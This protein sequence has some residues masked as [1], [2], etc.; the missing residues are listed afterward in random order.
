MMAAFVW[1][2]SAIALFKRYKALIAIVPLVLALAW[3]TYQVSRWKGR[4]A[5]A[6]ATIAKLEAA[7]AKARA[8]QIAMNNANQELNRRIADNAA[9]RHAQI[10]DAANRAV[11]DYA[12]R[13]R[14]QDYCSRSGSGV[15]AVPA[16]PGAPGGTDANADLVAVTR[17]DFEAVAQAAVRGSEARGFL[18]D[19]VNEGLA[20]VV[21]PE[22][23]FGK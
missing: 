12:R 22:P 16:D 21:Y 3:Q 2:D 18:I 15:A 17:E 8:D 9:L 4:E 13:N 20:V 6:R 7:S 14:V 10:A 19:L 5:D 11:S 23:E 1:L